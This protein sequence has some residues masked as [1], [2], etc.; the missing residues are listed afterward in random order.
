[1]FESNSFCAVSVRRFSRR[2][3]FALLTVGLTATWCLADEAQS[4]PEDLHEPV[5]RV[6]SKHTTTLETTKLDTHPLDPALDLADKCLRNVEDKVRDYTCTII[7][8]ERINGTLGEQEFIQAKIR[9]EQRQGDQVV[10]PFSVYLKFLK[11]A[12]IA[13]Q[14]VIFVAGKNDGKL[15]AHVGG[16]KGKITPSV[17][18]DPNSMLAMR[19]QRYPITDIGVR[20]LCTRLI[21]KGKRDRELGD[22]EVTFQPAKINKRPSTCIEVKHL[23][24][25]PHL[26]FHVARIFMDDQLQIPI[27][28]AAYD[29]PLQPGGDVGEDELI[30][31]YTYVNI[32]TNIGLEDGDF[33]P[34]NKEYNMQ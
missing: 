34:A 33:D 28:Y 31:E 32:K 10:V 17:W 2:H 14:E 20:T 25:K 7:K 3:C 1:M 8:R 21:E 11:P 12:T 24:R 6:T 4:V 19:N 9:N 13:G 30:E 15:I 29:W 18:L 26:D 23:E 16:W 22:C 27:R 5:Y